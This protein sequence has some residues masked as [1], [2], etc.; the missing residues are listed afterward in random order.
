MRTIF[1]LVGLVSLSFISYSCQQEERPTPT[2]VVPFFSAQWLVPE[3]EVVSG[4][5]GKDGIPSIDNPAFSSVDQTEFLEPED[6]V[7]VYKVGKETHIYPHKI[8]DYHEIVN[9]NIAELPIAITYCPLTGTAL[10]WDRRIEGDETTFGVS[11]LLYNSNMIPYDRKTDSNW[12]QLR[13]QCVNGELMGRTP[14]TYQL[15]ETT[16]Q[17]ART[18][19]PGARVLNTNTGYKRDYWLYPYGNYRQDERILFPV[20]LEDDRFPAKE[21][22]MGLIARNGRIQVFRFSSFEEKRLV[23]V[24]FDSNQLLVIGDASSDYLLAYIKPAS[25]LTFSTFQD[26]V[27]PTVVMRDSEGNIWNIFGEAVD[28]PRRGEQLKT[29]RSFIGF[30]FS[31]VAFYPNPIIFEE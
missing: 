18:W 30:W 1:T 14:K 25:S 22:M 15:V 28:G 31:W 9:D 5:P 12:S 17:T 11:G 29:P 23:N 13:M 10:G 7:L 16:W 20:A 6:L 8:L 27:D 3:A 4:G 26:P 2:G 19:F 21:R 24:I